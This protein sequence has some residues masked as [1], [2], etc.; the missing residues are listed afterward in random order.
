MW[1]MRFVI[2]VVA[3][4]PAALSIAEEESRKPSP[5]GILYKDWKPAALELRAALKDF[6]AEL[7]PE[8]RRKLL[9]LNGLYT[10]K[11][12]ALAREHST[13]TDTWQN[14]LIWISVEGVPGPD[15]DAMMDFMSDHAGDVKET[16]QLQLLLPTFIRAQSS[17]LDPALRN[18]AE[19]HH[20]AGVR[21]SALYTL[22]AR[23][24]ARAEAEY[25]LTLL[26]DAEKLLQQT[27]D[28]YAE[29]GTYHGRNG[30]NAQKLLDQLHGP[31]A[32]GRPAPDLAGIDLHGQEFSLKSLKGRVI[33][34]SF[35]GHWC[36]P[37]RAMHAVE[38][39]LMKKHT[40]EDVELIEINSDGD[41]ASV[42]AT[43]KKDELTWRCLT[44]G[45]SDGPLSRAWQIESWPTFYVLDRDHKIRYKATG[46]IGDR[47]E[48][49]VSRL[50]DEKP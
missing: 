6:P 24:K 8:L 4:I 13:D 21:G 3:A 27:L 18:L 10:T 20:N 49:W 7:R 9:A 37:C 46:N 23:L 42:A 28:E 44:D 33:V 40:R 12:L 35:S 47:L 29:V 14:C 39:E 11:F 19:T 1:Q 31:F 50:V 5:Y 45:G 41:P 30:D 17:R 15:Y 25:S 34:L 16:T 36:G 43:M 38:R 26:A 2:A 22:A 48:K 32:L